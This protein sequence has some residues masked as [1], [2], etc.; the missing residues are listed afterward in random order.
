MA[1]V[2]LQRWGNSQGVRIPKFILEEADIKINDEVNIFVSNGN[3][4]IQK[5]YARKSIQELFR[6]YE[7]NSKTEEFD[8]GKPVGD[9][10]W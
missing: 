5:C 10:L 2:S 4:I 3:I 9:E 6:D 8:W 7:G 1:L